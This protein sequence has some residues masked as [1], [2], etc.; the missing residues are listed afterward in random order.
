MVLKV[1][2]IALL[3]IAAV[4]AGTTPEG[5]MWLE[6]KSKE[7]GVHAT[8]SGLLFKILKS[9][10]SPAKSPLIGTPTE[11]HYKGTLINGKVS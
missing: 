2:F 7:E 6:A 9:S 11:C 10:P 8:G 5:R 4:L 3:S 1:L